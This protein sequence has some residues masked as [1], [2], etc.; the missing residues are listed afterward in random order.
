MA[1]S[2]VLR[3]ALREIGNWLVVAGCLV[4]TVAYYDELKGV[5]AWSLGIEIPQP[6]AANASPP[7]PRKPAKTNMASATSASGTVELR[8]GQHGHFEANVQLNGRT[9]QVMVDTGASLVALTY[10]DAERAGIFV[11]NSDFTHQSQTAN[12]IAKFAP[13][14][15]DRVSIGDITVRNVQA[16]VSERGKLQTS[17]LGMSFLGKLTRTEMRKGGVLVLQE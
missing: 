9:V 15:L 3:F 12:G 1:S 17:L 7:A 4:G 11:R 2:S 10:E 16:A 14:M 13:V 8:A 6:S 5:A